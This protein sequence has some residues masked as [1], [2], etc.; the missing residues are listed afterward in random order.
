[1]KQVVGIF[2][3]E[4]FPLAC[5]CFSIGSGQDARIEGEV[6]GVDLR[7]PEI[8]RMASFNWLGFR[9]GRIRT[10]LWNQTQEQYSIGPQTKPTGKLLNASN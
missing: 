6:V 9:F 1:M 10:R 5:M 4:I 8:V 7:Q 3:I 2:C